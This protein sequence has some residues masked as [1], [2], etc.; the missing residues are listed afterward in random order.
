MVKILL[1]VLL[2]AT[3]PQAAH[4][5]IPPDLIVSVGTNLLQI[6]G[7]IAL[8]I[9]SIDSTLTLLA[10][11]GFAF[12]KRYALALVLVA[13]AIGGLVLYTYIQDYNATLVATTEEVS[14]LTDRVAELTRENVLLGLGTT[15]DTVVSPCDDDATTTNCL[16]GRE[17]YSESYTVIGDGVVLELDANRVEIAAGSGVFNHYTY[18]NGTIDG[19]PVTLYATTIASTSDP[20]PHD[21]VTRHFITQASDLSTRA[22]YEVALDI[23]GLP[24]TVLITGAEGDF[25]TRDSILYTRTHSVAEAAITVGGVSRTASAFVERT[26]SLDADQGVFFPGYESVEA[27]TAQFILWDAAG[28]FYLFDAT[29]VKNPVPR[30]RSHTWLLKK[31]ADGKMEK[32]FTGSYQTLS[33]STRLAWEVRMPDFSGSVFTL[34]APE[35][36]KSQDGRMRAELSGTVRDES[37]ERTVRGVGHFINE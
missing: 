21:F 18:L 34:E 28:N 15:T 9:M 25:V 4:A 8:A 27:T 26:H 24:V 13:N 36:F 1:L 19:T 6:L 20:V 14:L 2:I 30:Y 7:I 31:F 3:L 33:F 32:S 17:F 5:I 23:D 29:D 10:L 11:R 35:L 16:W 22:S 12:A 37:G